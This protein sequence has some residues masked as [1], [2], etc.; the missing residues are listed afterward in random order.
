VVEAA[1]SPDQ[2]SS[3]T[4]TAAA[5]PACSI[6]VAVICSWIRIDITVVL[7]ART[8]IVRSQTRFADGR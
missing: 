2:P 5:R 1:S 7:L 8:P 4:R 6:I 3:R